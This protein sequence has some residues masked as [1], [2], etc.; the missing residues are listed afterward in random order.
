MLHH[1]DRKTTVLLVPENDAEAVQIIDLAKALGMELLISAQPHGARL[2]YE[3]NLLER[4]QMTGKSDVVVVEMPGPEEEARLRKIGFNIMVIDHH[5][6]DDGDRRT[7]PEPKEPLPSALEQFLG[8]FD[9]T[10]EEIK[11][12]GFDP[13]MVRG[14]GSMD[15]GFLWA[16]QRDGYSQDEIKDVSR[17]TRDLSRRARGDEKTDLNEAAS[18]RAWEH[19]R[20]AGEYLVVTSD[21]PGAEIRPVVSLM[22]AEQFGKPTPMIIT[23]RGGLLIYVQETLKA[24]ELFKKF[25][26]FTFGQDTC[27]GYNNAINE[28]KVTI[29]NV[30]AVISKTSRML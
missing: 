28:R 30:L 9:V 10:D 25:G 12:A 18:A 21:E 14:V 4:L 5:R 23:S 19:R 2:E 20:Q 15:R 24:I 7:D 6:S 3:D 29:E 11:T 27:W 26:G 8:A 16:L 22:A 17:Y 1:I 13:R